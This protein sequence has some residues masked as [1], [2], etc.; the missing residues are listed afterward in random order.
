MYKRQSFGDYEP[1][2][3]ELINLAEKNDNA[4]LEPVLG[5]RN[6]LIFL[7]YF[8]YEDQTLKGLT[9][10]IIPHDATTESISKFLQILFKFS[11][12][13]SLLFFEELDFNRR[14]ELKSDKSFFKSEIGNGDI[15]S[16]G[17]RNPAPVNAALQ[18][19][20]LEDFYVFIESRVHFQIS[21]LKRIDEDEEDYVF[22]ET[23]ENSANYDKIIDVWL[24]YYS[25]Y[26]DIATVIGKEISVSPEYIKLSFISNGNKVD[27]KSDYD[28]TKAL[29]NTSK[30]YT[31]GLYYEV[32]KIPLQEFE[33]ME[34]CHIYWVGNGVCKEERHDFYL[35]KSSTVDHLLNKL[36][37]KIDI[38]PTDRDSLFGW[39]PERN[40][41]VKKCIA[42]ED[43]IESNTFL[44]VGVF[45]QYKEIFLSKSVN[46]DTL[47]VP[48]F[49]CY[50]SIENTHG[51]PFVFDIVKGEL[52]PETLIRLR[53]L[54]GLSE[55]EF[56]FARVGI[57]NNSSGIEYLDPI[58]NSAL[59]LFAILTKS[60]C[61][62][63]LAHPDRKSR[64]ASQH[65]SIM[66]KN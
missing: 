59:E 55:K 54:M 40:H 47:L 23:G 10:M 49:Q 25:T 7:K 51:L 60:N 42:F 56:K 61:S 46:R 48:G 18:F 43:T 13:E 3:D 8:S 45:P 39:I 41:K 1:K 63:V 9:H 31:I 12:E 65:S 17:F 29:S 4:T 64:R 5:T 53:K 15:I 32:L 57:T 62:L 26:L 66:I 14:I 24:S 34:L 11:S 2:F 36:E 37:T 6:I 52:L 19:Q 21:Q 58:A 20:N 35:P 22:I 50:G 33:G 44:I 16:F 28:F 38:D 27:L 30:Q